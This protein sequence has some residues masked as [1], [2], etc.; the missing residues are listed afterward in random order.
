MIID[1]Y[2]PEFK[3]QKKYEIEVNANSSTVYNIIRSFN[4]SD[5]LMSKWL[6]KLRGFPESLTSIDGLTNFGFVI[7]ADKKNEEIVFG[8]AG[9]F[10]TLSAN[11]QQ[12]TPDNFNDFR[13]N[14]YAKAVANIA[15]FPQSEYQTKVITETRVYCFDSLSS[16]LFRLYWTF[17]SPFSGLIRKEWLTTIKRESEKGITMRCSEIDPHGAF[18]AGNSLRSAN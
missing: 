5:S 13:E 6:F 4:M 14:G 18:W 10:W 17:I 16:F 7:L 8:L 15:L 2:C 9:K 11:I 12:L 1:Q 3:V